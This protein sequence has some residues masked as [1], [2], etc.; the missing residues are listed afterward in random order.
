MRV[1]G[2]TPEYIKALQA[3]GFKFD[4]DELMAPKCRASLPSSSK[5]PAR[6]A[7]RTS[8]GQTDPVKHMGVLDK[9]G[10]I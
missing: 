9:E 1:Q 8:L 10:E 6:T 4:A 2:V 5:K 7:F 3:A